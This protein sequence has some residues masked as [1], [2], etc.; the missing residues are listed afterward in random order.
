MDLRWEAFSAD[1]LRF[2]AACA[3]A[4]ALAV[5]PHP[6]AS[7]A[8]AALAALVGLLGLRL[9][10]WSGLERGVGV[11]AGRGAGRLVQPARWAG[12]GLIV[13][14]LLL[15]AIR[16]GIE[17]G[18][19]EVGARIAA[20]GAL[21][22]WQR[23]ARIYVAAVGE[24]LVFRL[25]LLSLIAGLAARFLLPRGEAPSRGIVSAANGLSALAFAAAHLP[26][27]SGAVR[28]GWT[29]AL[30]VVVLNGL[31]G[32]LFGHLFV[33]R[34]IVAAMWAHAGADGAILFVGPLTG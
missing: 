13:G 15:A 9:W 1:T 12:L 30:A 4:G 16:L 33:K 19:P 21:P 17:P 32:L 29:L 18:L 5:P 6:L 14:L 7:L 31:G 2:L 22:R 23:L 8:S 10:R 11:G 24:E 27:W 28:L 26:A 20:A 34:G 25:V 3:M